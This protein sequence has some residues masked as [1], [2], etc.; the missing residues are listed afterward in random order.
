MITIGIDEVGRGALIGNVVAVA[1]Y[2][3]SEVHIPKLTD[4]KKLSSKERE[5]LF[6]IIANHSIY[7]VGSASAKEIDKINILNATLLA[8]KRAFNML[9]ITGN[10]QVLVDGNQCPDIP[11]AQ[12]IIKGDTI[13][14]EISAASIIAK[15]LRDKQMLELDAKYPQYGLKNHKGYGTKQHIQ[16]I[17]EFGII[18]NYRKTFAPIKNIKLDTTLS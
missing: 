6:E 10:Y 9:K 16:A 7:A 4:S 18:T 5:Q 1:L 17:K 12:A 3:T 15:V 2:F 14:K 11:C 8:M 13:I